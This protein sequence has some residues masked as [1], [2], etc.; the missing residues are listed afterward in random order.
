MGSASWTRAPRDDHRRSGQSRAQAAR[1][2]ADDV[3]AR[4]K[5]RSFDCREFRNGQ[6]PWIASKRLDDETRSRTRRRRVPG[7]RPGED[8][9]MNPPTEIC[10]QAETPGDTASLFRLL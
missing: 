9:E 10:I 8:E 1:M 6:E 2:V 3:G 7:R 4:S 5:P